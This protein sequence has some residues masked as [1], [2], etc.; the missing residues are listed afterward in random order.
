MDLWIRSQD[1]EKLVKMEG[2][3]LSY[4][5]KDVNDKNLKTDINVM[6][7]TFSETIGTYKSKERA[8]EIL[9][10][11]QGILKLKGI[12]KLDGMYKPK[13]LERI[14]EKYNSNH[15]FIADNEIK[16]IQMPETIVYEMPEK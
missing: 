16:T 1:K 4:W 15:Y 9:D 13:D 8:M 3:R 7:R 6:Y 10:E 2:F 14:R 5:R 12:I 11:I